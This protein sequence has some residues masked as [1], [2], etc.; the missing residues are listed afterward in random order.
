M[1]RDLIHP[2]EKQIKALLSPACRHTIAYINI[3]SWVIQVSKGLIHLHFHKGPLSTLWP[4]S[5]LPLLPT[6]TCRPLLHLAGPPPFTFPPPSIHLAVSAI[7]P[8]IA[9]FIGNWEHS[10][11]LILFDTDG[12]LADRQCGEHFEK[13]KWA[14]IFGNITMIYGPMRDSNHDCGI[15]Q[16][17]SIFGIAINLARRRWRSCYFSFFFQLVSSQIVK[18]NSVSQYIIGNRITS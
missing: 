16:K 1:V 3:L 7:I 2:G 18:H 5:H 6:S 8:I 4:P 17:R 9:S 12:S 11:I 14:D 13:Q 15:L 10:S